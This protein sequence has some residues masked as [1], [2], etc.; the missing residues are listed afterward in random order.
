MTAPLPGFR[1]VSEAATV[2]RCSPWMIRKEIK[3]GRLRARRIGRLVRILDADLASW[4]NGEP[5][6]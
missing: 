3:E 5:P 6:C 2:A 4:M 1:L